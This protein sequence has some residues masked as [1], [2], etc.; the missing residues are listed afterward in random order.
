MAN[1]NQS[2]KKAPFFFQTKKD[3]SGKVEDILFSDSYER[4]ILARTQ[5][6]IRNMIVESA[7]SAADPI[8]F[9]QSR[10]KV[11]LES[12]Q[13]DLVRAIVDFNIKGVASLQAR[14]AGKSFAVS[15]GIILAADL[16]IAHDDSRGTIV[17]VFANKEEQAYLV[18]K[19][20]EQ[21]IEHSEYLQQR[22]NL[23][24][25]TKREI[26]WSGRN[27]GGPGSVIKF[28]SASEQA[29][30][31]GE[32]FDVIVLDESQKI[33]DHVFEEVIEPMGGATNAKIVQIGTPR[34]KNHFYNVFANPN[35][36][37]ITIQHD[38]TQCPRLWAKGA[39]LVNSKPYSTYVLKRMPLILRKEVFPDNPLVSFEN[40]TMHIWDVPL[41]GSKGMS[42]RRFR[43]Q[44]ML[45]WLTDVD[46]YISKIEWE[47]LGTGDF[48]MLE[49]GKAGEIYYAGID[50]TG[51]LGTDD[52]YEEDVAGAEEKPESHTSI[53]VVRVVPSG[54]KQ[55]VFQKFLPLEMDWVEQI[56]YFTDLFHPRTGKFNT[57]RKI[58]V[59]IG[60]VGKP[61]VD[62]MKSAGL[63]VE[64]ILFQAKD[65]AAQKNFKNSMY[66]EFH[67]ELQKNNWF[68]PRTYNDNEDMRIAYMQWEDIESEETGGVNKKIHAG[69]SDRGT[70]AAN[71]D[72]LAGYAS[73]FKAVPKKVRPVLTRRI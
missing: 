14:Q 11:K 38:W 60:N 64:G 50:C 67:F 6:S 8:Y 73:K 28:L 29:H 36:D 49:A 59:D 45:H 70:D 55:K 20:V 23:K 58:M 4:N 15:T 51:N 57:I 52:D 62:H 37:Y 21:I 69:N 10:M 1:N 39:V 33:S 7:R 9:A 63:P 71:S 56:Q 32:T 61:V 22:V 34:R 40:K 27:S 43:T 54:A 2:G 48:E 66:E 53:S 18:R 44:Y 30:I 25:S 72:V 68:Y 13:I 24:K 17:G 19:K 65:P 5:K 35:N 41:S 3:K 31:E 46:S 26:I 16:D 42:V 47:R 12:N